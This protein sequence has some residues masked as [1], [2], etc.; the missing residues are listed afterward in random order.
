MPRTWPGGWAVPASCSSMAA[1]RAMARTNC[2]Y[3]SSLVPGGAF[4]PP[5]S[6]AALGPANAPEPP[7][8]GGPRGPLGPRDPPVPGRP[9]TCGAGAW[10]SSSV[11]APVMDEIIT[12]K[13]RCISPRRES[14]RLS[15]VTSAQTPWS[16]RCRVH[17][18]L[19]TTLAASPSPSVS[20]PPAQSFTRRYS[21]SPSV[22]GRCLA[23]STLQ[24]MSFGHTVSA[25]LFR[26]RDFS[27]HVEV[28]QHMQFWSGCSTADLCSRSNTQ[29]DGR[30]MITAGSRPS[31]LACVI[32]SSS[33]AW[34]VIRSHSWKK[35]SQTSERDS[36]GRL[37]KSWDTPWR[38]GLS[39]T[40][41][42]QLFSL[43]RMYMLDPKSNSRT[44]RTTSRN[45]EAMESDNMASIAQRGPLE[46]P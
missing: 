38:M 35:R 30:P 40:L 9:K 45:P 34:R 7:C 44:I 43:R 22:N 18:W 15:L 42:T 41:G 2:R 31:R 17:S 27:S 12:G 20:P 14:S 32:Q 37:T 25:M 3:S 16:S 23:I 21:S 33:M 1:A 11:G 19:S 26:G 8:P 28:G 13:R 29:S 24:A 36:S 46:K 4:G 5:A 6:P 39:R 10:V